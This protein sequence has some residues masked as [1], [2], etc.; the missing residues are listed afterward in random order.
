MNQQTHTQSS[1]AW[2]E[3]WLARN[4]GPL[5]EIADEYELADW[6]VPFLIIVAFSLIVLMFGMIGGHLYLVD[7]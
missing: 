3:A 6:V 1:E 2:H 4:G 7:F 5:I